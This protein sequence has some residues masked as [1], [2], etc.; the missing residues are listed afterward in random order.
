MYHSKYKFYDVWT[1]CPAVRQS[2]LPLAVRSCNSSQQC[3]CHTTRCP[4]TYDNLIALTVVLCCRVFLAHANEIMLVALAVGHGFA[5]ATAWRH[6]EANGS[7][8]YH[9]TS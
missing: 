7:Y 1:V 6:E 3:S 4:L 5:V 9:F 8:S 2:K